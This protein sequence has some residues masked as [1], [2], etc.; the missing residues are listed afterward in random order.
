MISDVDSTGGYSTVL[1]G[2]HQ[3]VAR[4]EY[5]NRNVYNAKACVAIRGSD[6]VVFG[7]QTT[8]PCSIYPNYADGEAMEKYVIEEAKSYYDSFQ[9]DIP[10]MHLAESLAYYVHEFKY[11]GVLKPFDCRMCLGTWSPITGPEIYAVQPVAKKPYKSW[12]HGCNDPP[13]NAE[14]SKRSY[15]RIPVREL[16]KEAALFLYMVRNARN[17][18]RCI[19]KLSWVSEATGGKHEFVPENV[20]QEAVEFA[21]SDVPTLRLN[22][23][24]FN[25]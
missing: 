12:V 25:I 5:F 16:I 24:L 1:F 19:M 11:Q 3:H 4:Y 9:R 20:F 8:K 18:A 14:M 17:D 7:I 21:T 10:C 15:A 22:E 23:S 2:L 13:D 6:G